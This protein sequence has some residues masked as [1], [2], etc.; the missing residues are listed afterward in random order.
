M[1]IREAFPA[2]AAAVGDLR[3]AA[4]AAQ[5]LLDANPPYAQ[6]L[7]GLGFDGPGTVLVAAEDEAGGGKLAG[8]VMYEPWHPGSEVA[9]SAGEAEVRA[10]AVAP[11][12]QGRGAGRALM[13]AVIGQAEA[14]GV[15]RLLLSTRPAMTAA[16]A[17][18][19]SLDFARAPEL[20]WEPVPG[21]TLLGFALPVERPAGR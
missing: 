3:V 17:L 6:V 4:Y 7:R 16:Q 19:R 9:R 14:G 15:S 21:V 12:A 18:Y 10:L 1:I 8:T 5:G 20:D 11:G 2:E 13:R